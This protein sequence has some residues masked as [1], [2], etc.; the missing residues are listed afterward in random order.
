MWLIVGLGNPGS[1]YALTR[2]NIGFMAIDFLLRSLEAPAGK[3]DFKA[4][5]NKFKWDGE[6]VVT[7]M[8]Q[9]FMNLSGEAVRPIMDFYKIPLEKLIVLHDEVDVPFN[10]MRI[11]KNRSPAGNNGIK[12]ISQVLGTN[13]YARVRLGVGRPANPNVPVADHVL[14]K[15]NDDEMAKLPEFLNRA[16]DAVEC[17]IFQGLNKASSLFNVDPKP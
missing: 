13:D 8:P 11:H 15:F 9:T 2:H 10:H 12:S 16:V 4:I 6:E 1:K 5:V 17:L 7:A 3:S 14:Q